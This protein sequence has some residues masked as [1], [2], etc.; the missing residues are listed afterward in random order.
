MKIKPNDLCP[1]YSKRQYQDCCRPW[2]EGKAAPS[3]EQLMR[4]RFAAYALDNVGYIIRTTHPQS[5]HAKVDRKSWRQNL[6]TFCCQTDFL[7]LQI[8]QAGDASGDVGWVTFRAILMQVGR[9]VSFIEKSRFEKVN[10]R[11]LYHSGEFL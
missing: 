5:P 2:H 11:W 3:P 4:S 7:G 9:D 10:G 8:L 6:K 1:C